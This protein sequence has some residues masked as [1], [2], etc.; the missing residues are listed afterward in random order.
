MA[1]GSGFIHQGDIL[2]QGVPE[3]L[4][5]GSKLPEI[6]QEGSRV[7][8]I[9]Q[10]GSGVPEQGCNIR[11]LHSGPTIWGS[12]P[13]FQKISEKVEVAYFGNSII[14]RFQCRFQ[15]REMTLRFGN[16]YSA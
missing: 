2:S 7:P 11:K 9:I 12:G 6:L 1:P 15:V 16:I 3:I 13:Q 8:E 4:Q 10:E 5:N 14:P